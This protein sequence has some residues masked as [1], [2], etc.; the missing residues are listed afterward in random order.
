MLRSGTLFADHPSMGIGSLSEGGKKLHFTSSFVLL[1]TPHALI[2][3][4][5]FVEI[6]QPDGPL[7][8]PVNRG[9]QM[10]ERCFCRMPE[11]RM[12][13]NGYINHSYFHYEG[14]YWAVYV[15]NMLIF[16][17]LYEFDLLRHQFC[18][19]VSHK[20]SHG[21]EIMNVSRCHRFADH[22]SVNALLPNRRD[23]G[24]A[25]RSAFSKVKDLVLETGT[26]L[27]RR[28]SSAK[29]SQKEAGT[30]ARER[31]ADYK[32]SRLGSRSEDVMAYDDD[33]KTQAMRWRGYF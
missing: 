8:F 30:I 24:H 5:E 33:R 9:V 32:Y 7:D 11:L 10:G 1:F 2:P 6:L 4:V 15:Y 12:P 17:M 26:N 23:F 31:T 13:I 3:E 21:G 14:G 22:S 19:R 20:T 25:A 29:G 18:N 16:L 27:T 28:M